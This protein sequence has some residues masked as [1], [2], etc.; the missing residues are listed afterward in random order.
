MR[1][2]SQDPSERVS[3][4]HVADG[5]TS[6]RPSDSRPQSGT[7]PGVK[8]PI[9][10]ATPKRTA[11]GQ[12]CSAPRSPWLSPSALSRA[13]NPIP[14]LKPSTKVQ[15]SS[16]P[17]TPT[18]T[19]SQRRCR[20]LACRVRGSLLEAGG[21][22][23]RVVPPRCASGAPPLP[24][25]TAPEPRP[26]PN[27]TSS[28]TEPTDGYKGRHDHNPACS[29]KGRRPDNGGLGH[30]PHPRRPAK[31]SRGTANS[32]IPRRHR[33]TLLNLGRRQPHH[34]HTN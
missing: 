11:G 26:A 22:D 8:T 13:P 23:A 28:E 1:L 17:K 19:E 14:N 21:N 4:I 2:T 33:P 10:P 25:S 9:Q 7:S 3:H 30:V 12:P 29:P 18:D 15:W 6:G 16:S 31:P 20:A 34:S 32:G 24:R 5:T 27:P